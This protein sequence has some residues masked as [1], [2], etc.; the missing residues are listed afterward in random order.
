MLRAKKVENAKYVK[1]TLNGQL[2]HQNIE[3]QGP[4]SGAPFSEEKSAGPLMLQGGY[5]QVA[6]RRIILKPIKLD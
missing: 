1:V 4:T 6:F 5:G 3:V 2:I